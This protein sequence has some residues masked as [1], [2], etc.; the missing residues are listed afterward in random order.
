ME[1]RVAKLEVKVENL[2][3]WQMRQNG[4]LLRIERSIQLNNKWLVGLL[5]GI[6]VALIMQVIN[7]IA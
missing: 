1:E 3:D 5:G 4:T 6:I 7:L 2:E